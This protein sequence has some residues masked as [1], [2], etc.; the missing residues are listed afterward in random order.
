LTSGADGSDALPQGQGDA[1]SGA[2][3]APDTHLSEA[4]VASEAVFDGQFLKVF[5]DTVRLPDGGTAV[6]EIVRHPGAVMIVPIADDGRLVVERQH[7]HPIGQVLIEFPAGKIDP[8]ESTLR[9]AQRELLEETGFR[10]REWAHAGRM[11]NAP[12]IPPNSSRSGSRAA[13]PLAS[14][15]STRASSSKCC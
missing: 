3:T 15:G 12:R 1:R 7:R 13:S 6:R 10:A 4:P 14:S 9:C 8:G 5:R 2:K 11:H